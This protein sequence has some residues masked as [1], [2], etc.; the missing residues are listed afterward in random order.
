MLSVMKTIRIIISVAVAFLIAGCATTFKPWKLSEVNEGM[1]R[2][3]VVKILGAPDYAVNKDGAEYIYY[4]YRE[5]LAPMS[6]VSLE[7]EAGIERRVEKFN[8]TLKENKYEIK[9]VDDKVVTHKELE[10]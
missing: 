2:D 7:T 4:T 9:L 6:D 5:E 3:Q 10:D 1:E 8:R